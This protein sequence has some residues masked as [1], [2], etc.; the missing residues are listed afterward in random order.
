MD[1]FQE[2]K[3]ANAALVIATQT[4]R[5]A[6]AFGNPYEFLIGLKSYGRQTCLLMASKHMTCM[7]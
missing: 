4:A 6:C 5:A 7:P 2:K 3:D 1:L